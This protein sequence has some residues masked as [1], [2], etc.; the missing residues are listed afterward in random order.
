MSNK[1]DLKNI[2]VIDINYRIAQI[3]SIILDPVFLGL[4]I[5]MV[6]IIKSQMP[7]NT[8]TKWIISTL[9]LNA[10]VPGL[11][12]WFLTSRG[13][14]FDATLDNKNAQR[15]RIIIFLIYFTVVVFE[16]IALILIQIYQP[17]Y[18][19]LIGA[20]ISLMLGSIISYFF[21]ISIH[22]SMV[23]FFVVMMIL[24][25]GW[26]LWPIIVC[27]PL[28]FWSRLVLKR[29]TISQLLTGFALSLLIVIITFNY[30][31]LLK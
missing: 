24:I 17:L 7:T 2:E 25:F 28:I 11:F 30:F 6:S 19:V 8:M 18:A 20:A 14:V 4:V 10:F 12:Y 1:K 31:G 21:K 13:F 23:T 27:I 5:L 22:A 15:Q 3:V 9:I 16:I 29:H 26:N